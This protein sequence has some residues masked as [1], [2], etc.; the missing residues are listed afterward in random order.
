MRVKASPIWPISVTRPRPGMVGSVG[1]PGSPGPASAL[2][3]PATRSTIRRNTTNPSTATVSASSTAISASNVQ[4]APVR[5]RTRTASSSGRSAVSANTTDA[6][7]RRP[8]LP[9]K[10]RA[11]FMQNH[12]R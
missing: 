4:S 9:A 2:A 7:S 10:I 3:S 12:C 11:G 5:W 1:R 8:T 6:A